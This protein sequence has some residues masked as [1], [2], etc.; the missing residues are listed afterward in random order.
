MTKRFEIVAEPLG[1]WAWQVTFWLDGKGTTDTVRLGADENGITRLFAQ[2]E[3]PTRN[4]DS[5]D[6]SDIDETEAA[7][8]LREH[9]DV[10][11]GTP[12]YFKG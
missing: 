2:D 3:T 11:S 12:V 1:G 6:S 10:G 7:E 4:A 8:A 9:F 5:P